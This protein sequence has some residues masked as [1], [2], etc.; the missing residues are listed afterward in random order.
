[1]MHIV[2]CIFLLFPQNFVNSPNVFPH[3]FNSPYFRS[4]YAFLLNLGFS[5]FPYFDHASCLTYSDSYSCSVHFLCFWKECLWMERH[6]FSAVAG[7]A[8]I[9]RGSGPLSWRCPWL[10]IRLQRLNFRRRKPS[11]YTKH[12]CLN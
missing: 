4:I 3:F 10:P 2:Y 12:P 11:C 8:W 1:M 6:L 5:V 7:G 9:A